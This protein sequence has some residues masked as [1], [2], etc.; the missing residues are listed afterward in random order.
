[1]SRLRLLLA[2]VLVLLGLAAAPAFAAPIPGVPA[3]A[4]LLFTLDAGGGTLTPAADGTIT[5]RL[6][7]AAANTTWFT[8]RPDR[9]AGSITTA[10]LQS[11][12]AGFGFD[13]IPPNAALVL[14][15]APKHRDTLALE[16]RSMRYDA[17]HRVAVFTARRLDRLDGGLTKLNA[18]LDRQVAK[19][20]ATATLFIDNANPGTGDRCT[21]G[22]PQLMA[23][24]KPV[25]AMTPADGRLLQVSRDPVLYAILGNTFGGEVNQTYALPTLTAPAA[26]TAWN[27]CTEGR[28][29]VDTDYGPCQVGEADLWVTYLP[30]LRQGDGHWLPADGRTLSRDEYYDYTRRY[31]TT[32]PKLDAPANMTWMVCAKQRGIYADQPGFGQIDAFVGPPQGLGTTW[33]AADGATVSTREFTALDA[34]ING[35]AGERD[36]FALPDVPAPAPGLKYYVGASGFWILAR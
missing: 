10:R 31:G 26:G 11:E 4:S 17:R 6:H 12:W 27:I 25:E 5:L 32:L 29:P 13:E 7:G 14:E 20:F 28:F 9:S 22:Q 18:Q 33:L 19:R 21:L 24:S 36:R 8:D 35:F 23:T 34:V 30:W 3:N 15:T 2:A 16:L 1:V